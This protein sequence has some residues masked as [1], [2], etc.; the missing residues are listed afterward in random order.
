MPENEAEDLEGFVE[1]NK[2]AKSKVFRYA[3]KKLLKECTHTELQHMRF[4]KDK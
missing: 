3:I 1:K 2:L 4:K